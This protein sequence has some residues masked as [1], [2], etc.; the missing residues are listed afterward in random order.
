MEEFEC[1]HI[2][3]FSFNICENVTCKR[4]PEARDRD[5][6]LSVRDETETLGKCVSRPSRDRDVETKTTS[7]PIVRCI[8]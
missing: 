1:K 6:W 8:V 3:R 7:L 4:D 2:I 5:V